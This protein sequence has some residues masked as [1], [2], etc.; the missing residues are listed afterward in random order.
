MRS[1]GM[2]PLT[3]D[4]DFRFGMTYISAMLRMRPKP[5][6]GMPTINS[7]QPWSDTDLADLG[8]LVREQRPVEEIAEYLCRDADEG[9][10]Q[11][12]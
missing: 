4:S 11:N 7:G 8:E 10:G 3:R 2:A 9:R 6:A 12:R 5:P 1:A